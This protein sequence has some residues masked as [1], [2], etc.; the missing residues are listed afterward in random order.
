MGKTRRKRQVP[1][2]DEDVQPPPRCT[3]RA[4]AGAGGAL[5]QLKKIGNAIETLPRVGN[6]KAR[7]VVVPPGEPENA[8]APAKKNLKGTRRTKTLQQN[9][10]MVS[11]HLFLISEGSVSPE[12]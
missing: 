12:H 9:T 6:G 10:V 8:M 1:E 11:V 7:H 4:G 3:Q 2:S 5:S